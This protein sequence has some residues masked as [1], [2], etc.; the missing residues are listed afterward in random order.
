MSYRTTEVKRKETVNV[1]NTTEE[2]IE[3]NDYANDLHRHIQ[4]LDDT[5]MYVSYGEPAT[6]GSKGEIRL[7]EGQGIDSDFQGDIHAVRESAPT[8]VDNC[9]ILIY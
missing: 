9:S 6:T 2:I 5:I 8:N 7:D 4:N 1:G 3:T